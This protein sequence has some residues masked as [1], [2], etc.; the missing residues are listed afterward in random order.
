MYDHVGL[1]V[2]NLGRAVRFYEAAL[3]PLGHV[4]ASQDAS[5]AGLG[6]TGAPAL[7]LYADAAAKPTGL[8]VAFKASDRKS[9][10]RFHAAGLEAGGRDNG[11]PG[12]APTTGR[13]TT[14]HFYSTRTATMWKRYGSSEVWAPLDP[15]GGNAH[16]RPRRRV[17]SGPAGAASVPHRC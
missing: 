17:S 14:R 4:V 10:D 2:T 15:T 16:A 3:Q 8:H 13:R 11:K 1:K 5:G 6:P 12:C 7:W 9:V